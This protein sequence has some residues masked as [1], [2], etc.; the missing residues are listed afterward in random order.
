[1]IF[2][3]KIVFLRPIS[4]SPGIGLQIKLLHKKGGKSVEKTSEK[5]V[6]GRLSI[7]LKNAERNIPLGPSVI[8]KQIVP[9]QPC[10]QD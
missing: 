8:S 1:M 4:L 10:W 5:K 2:L 7:V 6:H 9:S 3:S